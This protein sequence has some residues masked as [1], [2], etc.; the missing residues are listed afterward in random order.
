MRQSSSSSSSSNNKT[1]VNEQGPILTREQQKTCCLRL[2]YLPRPVLALVAEHLA[3]LYSVDE[4]YSFFYSKWYDIIQ[5]TNLTKVSRSSIDGDL[6]RIASNAASLLASAPPTCDMTRRD[7]SNCIIIHADLRGC[8]LH[9][10]KSVLVE[11]K[12]YN[13]FRARAHR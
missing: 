12:L 7:F 13:S 8:D 6:I 2:A 10:C 9:D 4:Q 11:Y 3:L 5:L 1:A